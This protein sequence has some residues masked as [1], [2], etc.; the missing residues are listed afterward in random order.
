MSTNFIEQLAAEWYEHQGYF[1]LRNQFVGLRPKGGWECELDIV[2]F[3]P[4]AKKLVH[5]ECSND[6]ANWATR[7]VRY[8]RK[9]D[10]GKKFI[11]KMFKGLKLPNE[12]QQIALLGSASVK[13]N[14]TIGGGKIETLENFMNEVVEGIRASYID[15]NHLVPEKYHTLRTIYF[16]HKFFNGVQFL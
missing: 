15:T 12:V 4:T 11:P 3:S 16:M 2:A 10:A 1:V 7:E 9:F 13:N 6:A 5:I 14:Q 8:K